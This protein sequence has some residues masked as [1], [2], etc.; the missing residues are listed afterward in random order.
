MLLDIHST[1]TTISLFLSFLLVSSTL[2]AG[3]TPK[4]T[5]HLINQKSPYLLQHAYN[6]VDWYP[7]GEEAFAKAKKEDKPILLSIGYSTCHWCHVM[8]EE[9]FE[10]P[11]TAEL[12]NRNF[13]SIKVDREERPD[14]DS[15]Y[16]NYV[17]ATTGSGGWP[18]TVFL[19]P[20]K[21]PFYGGTYFP[22]ADR[23][24]TPGFPTLLQSLAE[25]WKNKRNEITKS[26][27]SAAA[28]LNQEHGAGTQSL[29]E[30]VFF[31]FFER[32]KAG[33][34]AEH[35]G[36]GHAPKF[37]RSHALSLLLRYWK[38][39]G[40]AAA[41]QMAE[42]TLDAMARGGMY[43]QLGGGFHRYSTD[44]QW[45]LPHFEKMLYDQA[46]LSRTYLEAYQATH[47]E[48]Y[49]KIAR[50]ILDYVLSQMTSPE[51]GF[52]SAED[53]DSVDPENLKKKREGAFF[54]WRKSEIEKCLTPEEAE[55]FIRHYGVLENG[56][57][58]QD[59]QGEFAGKNVLYVTN[60]GVG[61]LREAPLH[62]ARQKL[63]KVRSARPAPHLDDK[64]LADWNGLMISSF[65]FASR[66]LNEPRYRA[67]A[68]KA[69]EFIETHL[70]APLRHRYR[71]GETAIDGNLNDYAFVIYGYISLYEAT[72]DVKWLNEAQKLAHEMI[73]QFWDKSQGGFFLTAHGAEVLIAR[74][75]EIYDGAVPSGNSIAALDLRLLER[76]TEEKQFGEMA[77]KV[78]QTF[79]AQVSAEPTGYP[80]MLMALDTAIGPSM[81]II[82][83]GDLE[84]KTIQAMVQEIYSRFIPNKVVTFHRGEG[85]AV[86]HVCRDHVCGLP[87]TDVVQ[88]RQKLESP[89]TK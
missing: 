47:R 77:Q 37:P 20:D 78:L 49:A 40:N 17:M 9:S 82:L 88:L 61:A 66:V 11:K 25:A 1:P 26:A 89:N 10:D 13:V 54:V 21:K 3:R 51:G 87:I 7:W 56:N 42:K 67:A 86:A 48:N 80:Q 84:D 43:D 45:R 58:S 83:S 72:F 15:V 64:I 28:F 34:D 12:M 38:R 32:M 65:A 2:E 63:L 36:F 31:S 27:E 23:Y 16:M 85:K 8:E 53:A 33:F 6:P 57:V 52:Y 74:P 81:E 73:D 50:E 46:L 55:V 71:D 19:T 68:V 35:G 62:D 24:G 44:S 18:M 69:G 39:S 41:L 29:N 79:S 76:M 30:E 59:P 75:K 14:I 22:P 60:A 70:Q 5:N 4:F